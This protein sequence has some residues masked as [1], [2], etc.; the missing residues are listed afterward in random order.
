MLSVVVPCYN[1]EEN[2]P[3]IISKFEE[4]ILAFEG[5]I[6]VILV[7][8][9]S[10]DNSKNVFDEKTRGSTQNIKVLNIRQN[11]GYGHGI[12]SGLNIA[13]GDVLAWTH[14]DLQTDPKDVVSAYLEFKKHNDSDIVVKG[15]RRNRN[16][17]DAFFT[18]G[19]QV[20]STLILNTRLNDINA[21]P[22]L[23]SNTFFKTHMANAPM[24]FSLDL[25][26]LYKGEIHGEIK[27]IDVFFK[28]RMYGEAKGGGTF[29]GKLKLISRTFSYIHSLKKLI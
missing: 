20:Y 7:N 8:N 11:I 14:A 24:D 27:T 18:W 2:I 22:K 28:K 5:E 16:P 15:K 6:E 10:T 9:G 13:K 19:M 17:I 21:Q 25:F 1:E 3:L 29:K 23:F 26:L 12:V 4:I